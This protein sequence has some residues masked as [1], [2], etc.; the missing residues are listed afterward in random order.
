MVLSKTIDIEEGKIKVTIAVS[1]MGSDD[2]TADEEI[3]LLHDFPKKI[4][5][6]NID[7]SGKVKEDEGVYTILAKDAEDADAELITL[8]LVNK[9]YTLDENLSI[10]LEINVDNVK[11]GEKITSKEKMAQAQAKL[12]ETRIIEEITKVLTEI[13]KLQP[14]I[15]GSDTE[16]I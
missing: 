5:Y 11:A 3:E 7:F 1:E 9:V 13:R 14:D 16:T 4:E 2:Y 12:F 6:S 15:E 8:P 10:S